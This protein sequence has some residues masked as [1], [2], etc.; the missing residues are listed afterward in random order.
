MNNFLSLD[1][2]YNSTHLPFWE[3]RLNG[4]FT[5][6]CNQEQLLKAWRPGQHRKQMTSH[7]NSSNEKTLEIICGHCIS[8][9]YIPT[10]SK[11]VDFVKEHQSHLMD[12]LHENR[13]H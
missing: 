11:P 10:P 3:N 4:F 5:I 1:T 9:I 7:R 6:R 12:H 13:L 2:E 8:S